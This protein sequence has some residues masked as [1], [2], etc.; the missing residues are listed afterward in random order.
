MKKIAIITIRLDSQTDE[1]IRAL[2]RADDRSVAWIARTLII[3]ALRARNL[4]KPKVTNNTGQ[5]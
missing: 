5:P 2:A 3:E 4:L 1:I